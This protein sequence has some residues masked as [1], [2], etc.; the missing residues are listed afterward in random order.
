MRKLITIES[1]RDGSTLEIAKLL[2]DKL[3]ATYFYNKPPVETDTEMIPFTMQQ[4]LNAF[5]AS[6]FGKEDGFV[7]VNEGYRSLK[8]KGQGGITDIAYKGFE[9]ML[10][11]LGKEKV[12]MYH[13]VI[14]DGMD[15][16]IH[17]K[18]EELHKRVGGGIYLIYGFLNNNDTEE[19]VKLILADL[20]EL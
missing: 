16:G 11:T 3:Q 2:K 14:N 19:L 18:L 10:H 7:V 5:T 6:Q 17:D 13:L 12:K 15:W 4:M 8:L 20:E 9:S 1:E